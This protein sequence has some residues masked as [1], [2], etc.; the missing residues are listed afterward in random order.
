MERENR[1]TDPLQQKKKMKGGQ[2]GEKNNCPGRKGGDI[3]PGRGGARWMCE[4][5]GHTQ[6]SLQDY[7]GYRGAV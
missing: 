1:Y 4:Y 5:R 2:Q 7:F 3:N 6:T